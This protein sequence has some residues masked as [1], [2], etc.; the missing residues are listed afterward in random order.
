MLETTPENLSLKELS[1]MAAEQAEKEVI[2]RTLNEVYWNRR[3]AA[4]RLNICY[5]SL[6]NKLH[7]WQIPGR[8]ESDG[9]SLRGLRGGRWTW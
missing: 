8:F 3:Q 2:L 5:K 4:R 6:L 1:A 7:K 9:P